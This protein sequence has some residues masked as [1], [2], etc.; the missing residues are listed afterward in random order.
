MITV[1]EWLEPIKKDYPNSMTSDM[2][3][4]LIRKWLEE[5]PDDKKTVTPWNDEWHSHLVSYIGDDVIETEELYPQCNYCVGGALQMAL[6]KE[7]NDTDRGNFPSVENLAQT[8]QYH[9]KMPYGTAYNFADNI[10]S[11]NDAGRFQEAWFLV[12]QAMN[13]GSRLNA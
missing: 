12:G 9:F 8:L 5:L 1:E 13:W 2:N 11:K 4:G 3:E 10:I 6:G 7:V